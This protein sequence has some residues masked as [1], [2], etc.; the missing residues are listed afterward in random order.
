[1]CVESYFW[2]TGSW[3][4][5]IMQ[6]FD[7]KFL[8]LHDVVHSCVDFMLLS[9]AYH[10]PVHVLLQVGYSLFTVKQGEPPLLVTT[11]CSSLPCLFLL[12]AFILFCQ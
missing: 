6:I 1:M 2:V 4:K 3:L 11:V 9:K 8:N 5:L 7:C 12:A 10:P